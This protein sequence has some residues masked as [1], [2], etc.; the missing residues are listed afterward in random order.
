M[1]KIYLVL[2]YGFARFLPNSYSG[3]IGRLS[4][5]IRVFLVR[6]I[7]KKAGKIDTINRGVYFGTGKDVEMGD[8]SGIGANASIPNN[9]IIGNYVIVGR[10]VHILDNNHEYSNPDVP[11]KLQGYRPNMQ[12]VIEDD[13]WIGMRSFFTPGRHIK[14]G[15]I[16]AACSVVTKDFP[17]YSI[18]GGN[19]AKYIKTRG[20]QEINHE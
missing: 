13:V 2:Y 11:V 15:T 5:A 9:T 7:I 4:N 8:F 1:K 18:I 3:M 20:G 12:T 6:R 19:P 17:E 10:D 14:K 16:V